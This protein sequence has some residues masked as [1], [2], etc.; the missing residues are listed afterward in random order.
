MSIC[1]ELVRHVRKVFAVE[2]ALVLVLVLSGARL[3]MGLDNAL[4]YAL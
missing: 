2:N 1:K 4:R 3:V